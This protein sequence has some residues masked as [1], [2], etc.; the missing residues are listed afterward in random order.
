MCTFHLYLHHIWFIFVCLYF[1]V[2]PG[3]VFVSSGTMG[4]YRFHLLFNANL[5]TWENQPF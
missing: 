5:V 2:V 4:A 3:L 1:H